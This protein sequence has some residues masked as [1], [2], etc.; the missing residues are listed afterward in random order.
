MSDERPERIE[1]PAEDPRIAA[2]FRKGWRIEADD[3]AIRRE[4]RF[5]DFAEAFGWMTRIALL[6]E[7]MDHH[8]EWTNVWNRVEVRL[9]THDVGGL[10]D[11]DIALAEA[12]ERLAG[13]G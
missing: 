13:G 2:L 7:K 4:F 6:A 12:M 1:K 9:T 3:R 8:P 10:S 11:R 5:R